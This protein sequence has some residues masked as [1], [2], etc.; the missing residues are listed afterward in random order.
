MTMNN[1]DQ[2][3]LMNKYRFIQFQLWRDCSC[4]CDFCYNQGLGNSNKSWSLNFI[5]NKI[6]N[7]PIV[8]EFNEIGF[9]GGETFGKELSDDIKPLFYD[10]MHLVISKVHSGQFNK[11][12]VTTAL[13][14]KDL[15]GIVEFIELFRKEQIL[16]K[17]LICTSYDTKYR[18]KN[19][20][21]EKLWK[22]NVKYLHELFPNLH[23]HTQTILTGNFINKV[24]NGEFDI[25]EFQKEFNT[26]IDFIEPS[27]NSTDSIEEFNKKLP[28]FFPKRTDFIKFLHYI[29]DNNLTDMKKFLNPELHS[30]LLYVE[31]DG[32]PYEF[33]GRRKNT[34][35]L[36]TKYCNKLGR[37]IIFSRY[38][39]SE[40]RLEDDVRAFKDLI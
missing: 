28:E 7:D 10:L 5:I 25:L 4:G 11:V 12:Y 15:S 13:M 26:V 17:L 32:K 31:Y 16:D 35:E 39:D 2:L 8:N 9:I 20:N 38:F 18:F 36:L 30:D 33:F 24:L 27:C 22:T 29:S 34:D 1:L 14:F 23:I 37:K 3:D 6:K 19:A 21:S 40:K